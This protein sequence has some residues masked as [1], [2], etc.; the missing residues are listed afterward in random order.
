MLRVSINL[1]LASI[2]TG[3]HRRKKIKRPQRFT[4]SAG[5]ESLHLAAGKYIE[6][7]QFSTKA[8]RHQRKAG[9]FFLEQ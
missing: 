3:T 5:T 1:E 9:T 6:H 4:D 8:G 7:V 2:K